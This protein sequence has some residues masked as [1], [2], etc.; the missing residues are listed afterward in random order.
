MTSF[1]LPWDM[2]VKC[3]FYVCM[4]VLHRIVDAISTER[5]LSFHLG[6]V[7][8]HRMTRCNAQK[9]SIAVVEC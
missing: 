1:A 5:L 4:Y 7:R 6:G 3:K 9:L 2:F 8:S